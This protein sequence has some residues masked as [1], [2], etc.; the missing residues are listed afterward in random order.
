MRCFGGCI[1]RV[2]TAGVAASAANLACVALNSVRAGQHGV[3]CVV[4]DGSSHA[5]SG[6]RWTVYH[7]YRAAG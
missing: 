4:H 3:Q 2:N 5:V 7:R 1:Y 6:C